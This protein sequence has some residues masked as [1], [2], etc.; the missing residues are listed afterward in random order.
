MLTAFLAG[1]LRERGR[2]DGA[3]DHGAVGS[4]EYAESGPLLPEE[5]RIY[6]HRL[7]GGRRCAG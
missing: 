4:G 3:L 2:R 6:G 5:V 1:H 7:V